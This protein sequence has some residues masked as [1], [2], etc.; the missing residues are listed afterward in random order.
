MGGDCGVRRRVHTRLSSVS[1][2]VMHQ[3]ISGGAGVDM[4][5]VTQTT[6][7]IG[8]GNPMWER[9]SDPGPRQA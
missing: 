9:E 4:G 8:F 1:Q 7:H 3:T 5:Q 6:S 2:S